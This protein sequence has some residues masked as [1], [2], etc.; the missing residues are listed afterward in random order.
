MSHKTFLGGVSLRADLVIH[1]YQE[2][3]PTQGMHGWDP[4][5]KLTLLVMAVA[6]NVIIAQLWLSSL[7][8]VIGGGMAIWSRIP[9]RLFALFFLAPAWATLIVFLGFS[10]G[11]GTTPIFSFGSLTMYREGVFQGLS[12]AARVASDMSW[13]ASVFLTTPFVRLLH[14]LRWF[15]IPTVIVDTIAMAYR[16]AFLLMDGF[17]RMRDASRTRGGFQGYLNGLVSTARIL[18]QVILRAYD[19]AQRIQLAA[20]ARGAD[21]KGANTMKIDV[22]SNSC[23]NRCDVTPDY[24]D[25]SVPVL[26]CTDLCFSFPKTQAVKGV[27]LTVSKGE[28]VALCGPNGSGKTTLLRLF[29]GILTPQEGDIFVCGQRLDR[30]TRNE[31]FRYVG[32]LFQD[33]ND[34]L[35]CTHVRE[36]IAYGPINLGLDVNEVE[37]LVGTAMDLMEVEHLA[38]RPIHMLSHGEMRRVGLGGLIAMRPPLLLLDEPTASLDPASAKHLVRLIQHLNDHHGYTF[39][40]VTHDINVASFIAKRIIILD[41]GQIVADGSLRKILTDKRLLESAR[42][43]PPILTKLFQRI[44]NGQSIEKESEIPITIEEAAAALTLRTWGGSRAGDEGRVP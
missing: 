23:P 24:A 13:I 15:R 7:L 10:V 6:L 30:K 38:N 25:E 35:F 5:L 42:L 18:A 44:M 4:R 8:F 9:F 14:A 27:S 19:R 34:Q 32:I 40:I 20:T 28:V 16:Y 3:L 12:A 41:D 37:R 26:S 36:D 1:K 11:F 29:S 39:V 33:P 43:E 2:G 31:A 17:L 22:K 21:A